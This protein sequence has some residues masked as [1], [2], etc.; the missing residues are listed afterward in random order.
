MKDIINFNSQT[1]EEWSQDVEEFIS[2]LQIL[3]DTINWEHPPLG[4]IMDEAIRA[5]DALKD[6]NEEILYQLQEAERR[7]K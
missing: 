6:L 5:R 2:R 7:A 1:G 4:A 3:I